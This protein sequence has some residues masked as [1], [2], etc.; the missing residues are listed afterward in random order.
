MKLH[1]IEKLKRVT[2]WLA[3]MALAGGAAWGQ[4][5]G[6]GGNASPLNAA[7]I[8][9][10]GDNNAFTSRADFR[11]LDKSKKEIGSSAINYALLDGKTRMEFDLKQ[12]KSATMPP[13]LVPTLT[14]LGMDETVVISRP[15]KKEILS[16]FPRAKSYAEVA[17]SKDESAAA[18]KTFTVNKS[19]LGRE[20]ID[21]HAC[22]KNK[23]TL[24]SSQGE[25]METTVWNATDLKDFPVQIQMPAE[26][27]AMVI[28]KFKDIKLARPDAKQFEAPAGMTK[29]S[30]PEALL[31]KMTKAQGSATGK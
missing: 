31:D 24:T 11:I 21:G 19:P 4:M 23:V 8:K 29:Y 25:K 28:M 16:I 18:D 2:V 30:T 15:D 22:E 20:T 1:Y 14:Q 5:P 6:T 9:L 3:A 26:D 13:A 27:G 7:M 10:F 17:M 12:I